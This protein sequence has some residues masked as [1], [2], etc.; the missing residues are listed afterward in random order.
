MDADF[1]LDPVSKKSQTRFIIKLFVITV[2]WDSRKQPT[3]SA[4]STDAEYIALATASSH[5]VGFIQLLKDFSFNILKPVPIYEDNQPTIQIALESS[6]I[7]H[8]DV[9]LN[10]IRDLIKREKIIIIK[11]SILNQIAD[12]LTKTNPKTSFTEMRKKLGLLAIR[13]S[14]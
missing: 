1:A 8:L 11:I 2:F 4:S 7:K 9:K 13:G 3:V 6:R 14:V 10:F 5:T 12:C